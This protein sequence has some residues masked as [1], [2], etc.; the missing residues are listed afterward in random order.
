MAEKDD[1]MLYTLD[2][3]SN[4]TCADILF[5]RLT[6]PANRMRPYAF[7]IVVKRYLG[8]PVT[9]P[10]CQIGSCD[11]V[12]VHPTGSH[13]Y[14]AHARI[15]NRHDKVKHAICDTLRTLGNKGLY[16]YHCRHE[17]ALADIGVEATKAKRKD[18]VV[19]ILFENPS[20]GH[21]LYADVCISE[22]A[23]EH[24]K[25]ESATKK[26]TAKECLEVKVKEKYDLYEK[27]YK[28][29][30]ADIVPLV[31]D[32]YGGYA[33]RTISFLSDTVDA[34]AGED[35]KL[36]AKIARGL[37]DKL[38][39]ALHSAQAELLFWL[40]RNNPY[41]EAPKRGSRN[42]KLIQARVKAMTNRSV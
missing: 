29:D 20:T 26:R 2:A 42:P 16:S 27:E 36:K 9:K 6:N 39:V 40:N 34:V 13:A 12:Q 1:G 38:A 22:F 17:V 4:P 41:E 23:Y 11:S 35:E 10:I 25:G 14:H 37:R 33:K 8:L 24:W 3:T 5:V 30:K 31:I 21:C 15:T 7:R 32:T 28:L 19:D 18:R